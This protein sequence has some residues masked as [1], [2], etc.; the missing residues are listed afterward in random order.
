MSRNSVQKSPEDMIAGSMM[1]NINIG[2]QVSVL[3]KC[4][5]IC[6][7]SLQLTLLSRR[8]LVVSMLSPA[9]TSIPLTTTPASYTSSARSMI[10]LPLL[11]QLIV[12]LF[13]EVH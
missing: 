1:Q 2:H 7:Y 12:V 9:G 8:L 3:L 4:S 11:N 10:H 5:Y 6:F 13:L